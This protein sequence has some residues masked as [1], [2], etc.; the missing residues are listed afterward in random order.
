M[1]LQFQNIQIHI[2]QFRSRDCSILTPEAVKWFGF[3]IESLH[4]IYLVIWSVASVAGVSP[5]TVLDDVVI[6]FFKPNGPLKGFLLPPS[7]R[8]TW[9]DSAFI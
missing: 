5:G 4:I 9:P 7:R 3:T 6:L 2:F 1:F 8:L